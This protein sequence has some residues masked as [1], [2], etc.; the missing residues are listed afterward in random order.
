M[1][2]MPG[3]KQILAERQKQRVS[4]AEQEQPENRP[5]RT[6]NSGENTLQTWVWYSSLQCVHMRDHKYAKNDIAEIWEWTR[7]RFQK[8]KK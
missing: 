6:L 8:K 3:P 2:Q 4:Q 5:Y 7:T 1:Q